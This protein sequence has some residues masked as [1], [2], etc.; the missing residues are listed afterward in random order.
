M[1][2]HW[3]LISE[4]EEQMHTSLLTSHS[5]CSSRIHHRR[6]VSGIHLVSWKCRALVCTVRTM[7]GCA[8]RKCWRFEQYEYATCGL[9]L[10]CRPCSDLDASTLQ[11]LRR[12]RAV[13]SS[14]PSSV[15]AEGYLCHLCGV[16]GQSH[17]PAPSRKG[18]KLIVSSCIV[19]LDMLHDAE[20][21][22]VYTPSDGTYD[23]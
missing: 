18:Q 20:F 7:S 19:C 16:V 14:T 2:M 13:M 5:D 4:G 6:Y 17:S 9:L 8:E 10:E 12:R 1:H 3:R 15:Q 11:T 21:V 23:T 22:W